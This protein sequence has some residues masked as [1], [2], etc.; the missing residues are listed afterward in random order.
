MIA[1]PG[2][3]AHF[4]PWHVLHRALEIPHREL[5]CWARALSSPYTKSG[6]EISTNALLAIK[7]FQLA[8]EKRAFL[9]APLL[10]VLPDLASRNLVAA[11]ALLLRFSGKGRFRDYKLIYHTMELPEITAENE[12]LINLEKVKVQLALFT[13]DE[14]DRAEDGRTGKKKES[15]NE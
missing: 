8:R 15:Q 10:K 9:K 4:I 14:I 13:P 3:K 1:H 7:S 11:R 12:V 5:L 2:D 6:I